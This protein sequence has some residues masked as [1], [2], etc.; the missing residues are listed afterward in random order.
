MS[1]QGACSSCGRGGLR[2]LRIDADLLGGG[3]EAEMINSPSVALLGKLQS[4]R[5]LSWAEAVKSHRFTYREFVVRRGE[6]L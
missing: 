2:A 3:G 6:G 1:S 5:L 4:R